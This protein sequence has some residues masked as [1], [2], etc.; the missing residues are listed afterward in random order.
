MEAKLMTAKEL[1]KDPD[2]K[3]GEHKLRSTAKK[4]SDFPQIRIGNR[5]FYIKDEVLNWLRTY[6][7][8][9]IKL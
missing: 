9:G 3:I 8:Q 2:I 4:Y 1:V 6:S 7:K 5:R